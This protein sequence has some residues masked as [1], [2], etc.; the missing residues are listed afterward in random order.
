MI[1]LTGLQTGILLFLTIAL[2]F[3]DA[4]SQNRDPEKIKIITTDLDHFW[5]AYDKSLPDFNS[6]AFD[7]LYIKKG[8]PGL[9]G[10]MKGRIESAE[11][12]SA[13]INKR[14][15]YYASLREISL[16][17]PAFEGAIKGHLAKM[18]ALY[19]DAVF[20]PV[21]FVIGVMNSGGTISNNGLI[22]GVDMYGLSD[23]TP[24]NELS[25][26]HQE[27]I[28]SV[29]EMPH[30]VA[31]ELVHFQQKH[32]GKDLLGASIKEGAADFM[33]E[34][35]SGKHINNHVHEFANPRERELWLEFKERMFDKDYSG[36]LYS[37][38]EG[39]PNDLGYWMGY[40]ITKA[41]Y[42]KKPD[43]VEAVRD[44]MTIKDFKSFLAESGYAEK[45]LN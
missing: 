29:N 23:T 44:I 5:E 3:P 19:P 15:Q 4:H 25:A 26:W 43:K 37:S 27:V 14:P 17:I 2:A 12:L 28:K 7:Q 6:Q 35:V 40:Q 13:T 42:E 34:L 8:S 9:K 45:F 24:V 10:F 31:H 18:K 41:Y 36:W 30:I 11:N 39:R 32:N 22:I 1:P 16:K 20:P 33:A 21:Y 38:Q